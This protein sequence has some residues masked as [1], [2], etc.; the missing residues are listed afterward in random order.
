[1][2]AGKTLATKRFAAMATEEQRCADAEKFQYIDRAF[3]KGDLDALRGAVGDPT[4]VPN[5]RMADT[6]G[7]CLIYA[8]YHSPL[9][10]IRTLLELFADPNAPAD[11]GFPP[12]IAALSC[13]RA[14]SGAT[15]RADVDDVLRLLLSFGA[16]P[17]QRGINDSTPLHMAVGERNLL[18]IQIL[19]DGGA[20]LGRARGS[21]SVRPQSKWPREPDLQISWQCSRTRGSRFAGGCDRDSR[22]SWTYAA[23]GNQYAAGTITKFAF[24]WLNEGEAVHWQTAWGPVGAG[25]LEDDGKTLFTEVRI[26]RRSLINGLFYGVE[27]TVLA[28]VPELG[29]LNRKQIA[30]L[31]GVGPLARDSGTR[32][33]RVVT[34]GTNEGRTA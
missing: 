24:A 26:D 33:K 5:G 31:V 32:G 21:T 16:G 3:R 19:L 6:I 4:L 17:N 11:E 27:G 28:D 7:P 34:F 9:G 22:C 25:K 23:P 14:V 13:T 8:I 1:M 15:R 30:A 10:F 12:L 20:D 18:A 29:G 2:P